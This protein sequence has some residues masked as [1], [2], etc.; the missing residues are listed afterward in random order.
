[1]LLNFKHSKSNPFFLPYLTL[2]N[3]A[4]YLSSSCPVAH[5]APTFIFHCFLLLACP[6]ATFQVFHP[7]S[8]LSF[9]YSPSPCCFRPTNFPTHSSALKK[10]ELD[11]TLLGQMREKFFLLLLS[12][13]SF[14][15]SP[16]SLVFFSLLLLL[17]FHSKGQRYR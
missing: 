10:S 1:M 2:P 7:S 3:P 12:S 9:F 4:P 11:N 14:S 5:K 8:F 15:S 17:L 16:S 13:F 6:L